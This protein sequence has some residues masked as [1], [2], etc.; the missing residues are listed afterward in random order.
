MISK[1]K[2]FRLQPNSKLPSNEWSKGKT[3]I[4]K[5]IF[6][7]MNA[8][9]KRTNQQLRQTNCGIPCGKV[10]DNF[11][12]DLD[13]YVKP[14]DNAWNPET[15]IFN[16]LGCSVLEYIELHNIYSVETISGGYHL[17]FK[18]DGEIKTTTN[19][20]H[21]IDIRNDGSYV[22][23]PHTKINGKRYKIIN[24]GEVNEIPE[25]LKDLLMNNLYTKAPTKRQFTKKKGEI[26]CV[27]TDL[28]L[29]T[30][31]Y[32]EELLK[33]ILDNLPKEYYRDYDKWLKFTTAMKQIDRQDLWEEYSKK[34]A[35]KEYDEI[36]NLE[37][38]EG[39]TKHTEYLMMNH[40]LLVAQKNGVIN[41][42]N[43]LDYYTYKDVPEIQE[44]P[45]E[46]INRKKLGYEIFDE[47]EEKFIIVKSDTGTGKTS[48]FTRFI[49]KLTKYKTKRRFISIVSRVSLGKEQTRVFRGQ[50][51][52]CKFHSEITDEIKEHAGETSWYKH[53][54]QNIVITIDSLLK[55][56]NWSDFYGYTIYLDEINSLLDY[57][58]TA[59]MKT[60]GD[61][62]VFI[63]DFLKQ[64]IH[65]AH[66]VIMTDADV[67]DITIKYINQ[68]VEEEKEMLDG[69]TRKYIINEYKH[70]T[71]TKAIEMYDFDVF[72]KELLEEKQVMV[73]SD[74]KTKIDVL[75]KEFRDIG[76]EYLC[77]TGD[78]VY[79]HK[80]GNIFR[81]KGEF[82]LDDYDVVLFS[83]SIIYGLDSVMERPVYAIYNGNTISPEQ[84]NQQINR[85]RNI[86]ILKFMFEKPSLKMFDYN[87][88]DDVYKTLLGIEMN[89]GNIKTMISDHGGNQL[90]IENADYL[91]LK[92]QYEY[93][94][95]CY[96]TN[97]R[98]HFINILKSKGFDVQLE[99][100]QCKKIDIREQKIVIKQELYDTMLELVKTEYMPLLKGVVDEMSEFEKKIDPVK[101]SD[102]DL[103][104]VLRN[105]YYKVVYDITKIP[106]QDF[107][108][109]YELMTNKYYLY[110]Y[111]AYCR[112]FH[113][114]EIKLV[115]ELANKNDFLVNKITDNKNRMLFLFKFKKACGC[116][117]NML[118]VAKHGLQK[119]QADEMFKL[120]INIYRCQ[121]QKP[122]DF[123]IQ[124]NCSRAIFMMYRQL[125][126]QENVEVIR[127]QIEGQRRQVY[128]FKDEFIEDCKNIRSYFDE[129]TKMSEKRDKYIEKMNDEC[130][131]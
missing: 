67:N 11:V 65:Q 119:K 33:N 2:S 113:K 22:V 111:L 81:I 87:T 105:D 39:I 69:G 79:H 130:L 21:H 103:A 3:K 86:T 17:Y 62:R 129:Y 37:L 5:D 55:M 110:S 28:T 83:P 72:V 71:G 70:N 52:K 102:I 101:Y 23:A 114:D 42:R 117:N 122:L 68:L 100:L 43:L 25:D 91:K 41:A 58:I 31:D 76:R 19:S 16:S 56:K 66:Q 45:D 60:L 50:K 35:D 51:I 36:R 47:I 12:V 34:Y 77:I 84:Y 85:N 40:I 95:D 15:S 99:H 57:M 89:K 73:C 38:W 112:M 78:G 128:R 24:D 48:S 30:Y 92:S 127:K 29:Y 94:I 109:F 108:M 115:E 106:P 59:N 124:K 18:Y 80:D 126:G 44:E 26:Q 98:A 49:H 64:I 4:T 46:I 121:T 97:P 93:R 125:F 131:I 96:N 13:F 14:G 7:N 8:W 88:E 120:Y 20:T 123:T 6:I 61:N 10:N 54:G 75:A 9:I 32:P 90:T 116:S 118:M 82:S 1:F 104:N 63:F 27:D 107:G 74:S 53:E